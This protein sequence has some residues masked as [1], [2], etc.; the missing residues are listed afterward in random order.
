MWLTTLKSCLPMSCVPVMMLCSHT[1]MASGGGVQAG[2]QYVE[3]RAG[4]EVRDRPTEHEPM[5]PDVFKPENKRDPHGWH[6]HS[7]NAQLLRDVF[8]DG[9]KNAAT[10]E[11]MQLQK[12]FL[13]SLSGRILSMDWTGG[14]QRCRSSSLADMWSMQTLPSNR[15]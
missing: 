6:L 8:S 4:G 7:V 3:A 15:L 13:Q 5:S 1:E 12:E 2:I 11:R 14:G 9:Q 10:R